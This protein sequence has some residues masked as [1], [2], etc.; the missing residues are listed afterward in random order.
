MAQEKGLT[1]KAKIDGNL[2][3]GNWLEK[4]LWMTDFAK[5]N[6]A[7]KKGTISE[8]PTRAIDAAYEPWRRGETHLIKTKQLSYIQK[9]CVKL[10]RKWATKTA[11]GFGPKN[12]IGKTTIR[13]SIVKHVTKLGKYWPAKRALKTIGI[14]LR[15]ANDYSRVFWVFYQ[16]GLLSR[17]Q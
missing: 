8:Q 7:L 5:R 6:R 11:W 10:D 12:T 3:R 2:T 1:Y 13:T 4:W 16:T 14:K 17:T 9:R 15:I